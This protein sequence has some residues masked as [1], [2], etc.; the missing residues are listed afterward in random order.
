MTCQTKQNCPVIIH[1]TRRDNW[2]NEQ[3]ET[4]CGLVTHSNACE[5]YPR[6]IKYMQGSMYP[7]NEFCKECKDNPV[8]IMWE[9][10]DA[11]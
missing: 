9:L 6:F 5:A 7:P 8:L 1:A 2:N 3:A 10:D 11:L 4:A